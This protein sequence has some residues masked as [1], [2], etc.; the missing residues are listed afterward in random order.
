MFDSIY[1]FALSHFYIYQ[2]AHTCTHMYTLAIFHPLSSVDI[3]FHV[4][5]EKSA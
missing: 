5:S 4:H 3:T 1:N 2:H